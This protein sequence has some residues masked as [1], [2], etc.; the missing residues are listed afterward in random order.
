MYV[1]EDDKIYVKQLG[2][3]EMELF[4]TVHPTDT[5][6]MVTVQTQARALAALL[7][8]KDLRSKTLP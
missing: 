6:A 3:G 8:L 7:N 1:A 4:L 5:G 2:N